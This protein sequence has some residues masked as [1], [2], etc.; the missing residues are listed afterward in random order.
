MYIQL[1]FR[2]ISAIVIELIVLID[3][4]EFSP[5]SFLSFYIATN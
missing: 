1:F 5:R 4:S 2:P 3:K